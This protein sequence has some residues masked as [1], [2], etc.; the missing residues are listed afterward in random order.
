ME[1]KHSKFS[2]FNILKNTVPSMVFTPSEESLGEWQKRAEK[3]LTSLLGLPY[4]KCDLL[5]TIQKEK[6][7][8]DYK[9][10]SFIFQSEEN[11]FVNAVLWIPNKTT[12]EK[13]PVMICLQGHSTGMHVSFGIKKYD[14][15]KEPGEAGDRE[16]AI[17]CIENGFAAVAID[18][19]CFGERGG[20]PKPDCYTASMTALLT[21]RTLIG[22]RVWDIMNLIDVL[23]N[24]FSDV[25]D[26]DNI[27]CMGNSGGGTATFYATALEKR[28]KGA[29][30]SCALAT[31]YGSI[32]T[33]FHCACNFVPSIAKY[34]DMAEIAG[35]IAP[36]PLVIVSGKEDGIFPLETA[37][38]EFDRIK[39]LYY[40]N[41]E[42][43]EN[44]VHIKGDGGHRFYKDPTWDV[45]REMLKK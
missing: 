11:E 18:Q 45:F 25:L 12:Y 29:I 19:R 6:E 20:T 7:Y 36:R 42:K 37:E 41:S 30:P 39:N 40:K 2:E 10:I 21:G 15:D 44:C 5:F 1:I 32:G 27:Y 28:I 43:P 26:T 8:Q 24:E 9:E 35:L 13:T 34:F 17:Q 4:K 16:F 3:K 22:G 33:M 31:F 38:H 14:I 23:E